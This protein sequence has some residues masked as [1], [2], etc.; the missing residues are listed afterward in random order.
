MARTRSV[1][2][3]RRRRHGQRRLPGARVRP[4]AEGVSGACFSMKS[5]R[6]DRPASALDRRSQDAVA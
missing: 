3:S 2:S 6:V 1:S 4:E 5:R